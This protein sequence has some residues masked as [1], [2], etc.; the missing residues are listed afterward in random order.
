MSIGW[1]Y[2]NGGL[3]LGGPKYDE[4]EALIQLRL[5]HLTILEIVLRIGLEGLFLLFC[6]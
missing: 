4:L 6:I 2:V 3:L 5:D 1:T